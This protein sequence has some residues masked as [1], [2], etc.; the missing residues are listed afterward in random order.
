MVVDCPNSPQLD[1]LLS[2]AECGLDGRPRG[3]QS[4][5]QRL[6]AAMGC[7]SETSRR[8]GENQVVGLPGGIEQGGR[9]VLGFKEWVICENF[10]TARSMGNQ[11]ENV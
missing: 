11:I 9:D 2:A 10:L 1:D 4:L 3:F 7:L 5:D 6:I 8:G